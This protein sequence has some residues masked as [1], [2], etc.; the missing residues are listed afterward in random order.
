MMIHCGKSIHLSYPNDK[1]V[2][3]VFIAKLIRPETDETTIMACIHAYCKQELSRQVP[4][5]IVACP[6]P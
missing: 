6:V 3:L 1:N 5:M 2:E 4:V